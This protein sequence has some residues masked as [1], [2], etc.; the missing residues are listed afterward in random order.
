MSMKGLEKR[1]T[2]ALAKDLVSVLR[3]LDKLVRGPAW[4]TLCRYRQAACLKTESTRAA[5]YTG[6]I[7]ER[8]RGLFLQ[9]YNGLQHQGGTP[10][11]SFVAFFE[12]WWDYV[13]RPLMGVRSSE[14]VSEVFWQGAEFASNVVFGSQSLS[15]SLLRPKF[16]LRPF[17]DEIRDESKRRVLLSLA[18]EPAASSA[19]FSFSEMERYRAV[20]AAC[21]A[22]C[23]T[24]SALGT[25]VEHL[26]RG[27][28]MSSLLTDRPAAVR[29][30]RR[31]LFGP[32]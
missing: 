22:L 14:D 11:R 24:L 10:D 20:M 3:K 16:M 9:I 15:I 18:Y 23:D 21:E 17:I 4:W 25:R 8:Y 6:I 5:E 27:A 30:L 13:E 26:T 31:W 28:V 32:W 29:Q 7:V 12:T 19:S 2:F 1:A